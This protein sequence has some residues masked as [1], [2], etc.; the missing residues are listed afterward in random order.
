M[1]ETKR[2]KPA[3]NASL[4]LLRILS[5]LLIILM[6]S[7]D[8]TGVLE[9]S[10]DAGIG[11]FF[12]VR[13]LY[14]L[15]QISVNCYVMLSGYFLVRSRFRLKKLVEIWMELVFYSFVI[16]LIFML[17]GQI[18]F[19]PISLLS[20]FF[21]ILTGRYWFITIYVGL[22]L[23][24]PFLNIAVRAMDR[25]THGLLILCLCLLFSAWNSIYPS[26]AGMNSGGGWGLAWFVVLY[27]T[28]AWFS[29]YSAPQ[30][31]SCGKLMLW[32]G[33]TFLVTALFC[34]PG[35]EIRL[36]RMVSGTWYHYNSLPV[37]LSTILVFSAFL[38]LEIQKKFERCIT[39]IAP[40]T[41]GVYLIHA[42]ANLSP[43]IWQVLDLPAKMDSL[44]FFLLLPGCVLL[45][46]VVCVL[47][48]KLRKRTVGRLE[49]AQFVTQICDGAETLFVRFLDRV[50]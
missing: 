36:V 39:W 7:I 12:L 20:C 15:T 24:S 40:A 21:P 18:A 14:M 4:D 47:L 46:F 32:L 50:L 43:W 33:I 19:S 1:E 23:L 41:L 27:L 37:Y 8:H 26:I 49:G 11:M 34:I 31:K 30:G 42:H 9:A 45:I 29:L 13:F 16:K 28:A 2:N 48:D 22:Y 25:R 17:T 44:L 6:H 10:E 38:N 3:R 35:R 5:M